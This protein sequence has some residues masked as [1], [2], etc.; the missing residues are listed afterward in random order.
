MQKRAL[1]DAWLAF[2]RSELPSDL[3]RKALGELEEGVIPRLTNPLLL[4]DLLTHTLRRGGLEAV[5]ALKGIFVLV[6]RHGL[7]YPHFYARLYSLLEPV[8]LEF[9][10]RDAF[11]GL[12]DVFLA[13]RLVSAYT[14]AAFAKRFARIALEASPAGALRCL[15]FVHNLVRRHPACLQLLH[16]PR[17]TAEAAGG[18]EEEES[19]EGLSN[20]APFPDP[21]DPEVADPAKARALDSSLWELAALRRHWNPHV[22]AACAS[23][24]RDL[25]DRKRTAEADVNALLPTTYASMFAVENKRRLKEVPVAVYRETPDRLVDDRVLRDLG[26]VWAM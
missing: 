23:L 6:T 22:V 8:C 26:S 20:L 21:Y 13:S 15:A 10:H 3:A 14:A 16:R 12:V 19:E 2:L 4:S 5:L 7:E 17:R 11:L 24:D 9:R 18:A 25:T 1:S